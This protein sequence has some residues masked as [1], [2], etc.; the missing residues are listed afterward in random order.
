M[1]SVLVGLL[2]QHIQESRSPYLHETEA[3]ALGLRLIYRLLDTATPSL[4]GID[5]KQ[6]TD[7]AELLGFAGLN[8]THPYKQ[9]ALGIA[10]ERT[11]DAALAGST[12]TIA[13]RNGRRVAHNTDLY[14]FERAFSR[15]L[16]GVA[17]RT[18]LQIGAGGAG[19]AVAVALLRSG[20]ERLR[21]FDTDTA[22]TASLVARLSATF[23]LARIEALNDLESGLARVDGV[24]NATPIGMESHPGSPIPLDA[25]QPSM[26][27]A[28]I[29]YFPLETA[30]LGHA[31]SV[32]CRTMNGTGMAV[33]QAA[34]AFE[35]FTGY[36]ADEERMLE[37]LRA[38]VT[39]GL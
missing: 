32:G 11:D 31:K 18:C 9:W 4:A 1:R 26:W 28:D 35:I 34:R 16:A 13:F 21:I 8:V 27:V 30:L 2:G 24:V 10:S 39:H 17:H 22:R 6:L 3:D 36:V 20:I 12:N 7:A 38:C 29:I 15:N 25:L 23:G 5:P 14:G 37:A 19:G 33:F